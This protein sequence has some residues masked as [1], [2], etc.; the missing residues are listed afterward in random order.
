M[1]NPNDLEASAGG[2]AAGD[3]DGPEVTSAAKTGKRPCRIISAVASAREWAEFARSWGRG[4]ALE[5]FDVVRTM[6]KVSWAFL[7][8]DLSFAGLNALVKLRG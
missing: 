1:G 7:G 8:A 5:G 4:G 6:E 3:V 2:G